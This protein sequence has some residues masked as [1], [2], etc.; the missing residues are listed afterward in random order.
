MRLAAPGAMLAACGDPFPLDDVREAPAAG[1]ATTAGGDAGHVVAQPHRW[2]V[3]ALSGCGLVAPMLLLTRKADGAIDY[4]GFAKAPGE[5]PQ[6]GQ[7]VGARLGPEAP[8]RWPRPLEQ[9]DTA[10]GAAS[11][12]E[13]VAGAAGE[14]R[15]GRL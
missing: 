5:W 12:T 9:A 4:A 10:S 3:L 6:Q 11:G 15:A 14:R 13:H 1:G 7:Q 2:L 8:A